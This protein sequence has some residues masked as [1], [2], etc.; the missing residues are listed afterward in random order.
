MK[1]NRREGENGVCWIPQEVG[2]LGAIW[3]PDVKTRK[4]AQRYVGQPKNT[5]GNFDGD[6]HTLVDCAKNYDEAGEKQVYGEV[7]ECRG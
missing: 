5:D 6:G 3:T 1:A 2:Q 7:Q 4:D